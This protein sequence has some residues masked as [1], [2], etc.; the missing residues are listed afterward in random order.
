[1]LKLFIIVIS[2]SLCV[3]KYENISLI[4][5][6]LPCTLANGE[7]GKYAILSKCPVILQEMKLGG[8][9]PRVCDSKEV[10]WDVVCCHG[11]MDYGSKFDVIDRLE[12][13][14]CV[15]PGTDI[16]GTYI[17]QKY[18]PSLIDESISRDPVCQFTLCENIICCPPNTT[19]II[20][21]SANV[22]FY[23]ETCKFDKSFDAGREYKRHKH[24]GCDIESD[25]SDGNCRPYFQ[26][27]ALADSYNYENDTFSQNVTLCGYNCCVPIV[28]CPYTYKK[29]SPLTPSSRNIN[30]LLFFLQIK[31]YK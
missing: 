11:E 21:E 24:E 23:H 17:H 18:C 1:M 20:E 28:C 2:A 14:T 29:Y 25:S 3:A 6:D 16:K 8:K 22:D 13:A 12:N 4:D 27:E 5:F 7:D 15:V 30:K 10:C 26:C 31:L 9:F 19:A